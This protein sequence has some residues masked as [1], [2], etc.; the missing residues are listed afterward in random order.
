MHLITHILGRQVV[1][2][3]TSVSTLERSHINVIFAI[4]NLHTKMFL[5]ILGG[6]RRVKY[7]INVMCVINSLLLQVILAGIGGS[8]SQINHIIV[9]LAKTVWEEQFSCQ[10]QEDPHWRK[11]FS[12]KI[13]LVVQQQSY[14]NMRRIYLFFIRF[15]F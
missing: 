6:Y 10:S 14:Q 15:F 9:I 11:A 12:M 4:S 8:T 5:C 7:F 13:S 3:D 1:L 2:K